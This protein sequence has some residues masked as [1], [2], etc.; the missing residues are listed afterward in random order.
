MPNYIKGAKIAL[1]DFNLQRHKL[2]LGVQVSVGRRLLWF[3]FVLV[4]VRACA[5]RAR[6]RRR[7]E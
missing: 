5:Q 4:C 7:G 2:A 3:W 6:V 1:L